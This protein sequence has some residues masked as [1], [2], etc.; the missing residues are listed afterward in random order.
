MSATSIWRRNTTVAL[1]GQPAYT[2]IVLAQERLV[3]NGRGAVDDSFDVDGDYDPEGIRELGESIFGDEYQSSESE[4]DEKKRLHAG[5]EGSEEQRPAAKKTKMVA[6]VC[7]RCRKVA[8][9]CECD[10]EI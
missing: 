1:F 5:L 4:E 10:L 7:D 8:R 9:D 6:R 3:T 2:Y